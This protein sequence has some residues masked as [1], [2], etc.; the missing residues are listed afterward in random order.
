VLGTVD[1]K[2]ARTVLV[3]HEALERPVDLQMRL[4]VRRGCGCYARVRGSLPA[5]DST[6]V[7]GVAGVAAT[8]I[9]AWVA[10]WNTRKATE[11]TVEAGSGDNRTALI[12]AREDRLWERR[13]AAYEEMLAVVLHRKH[14]R[15]F[16]LVPTARIE[17]GTELQKFLD[18]VRLPGTFEAE[19]RLVAYAS[20]PVLAKYEKAD[21]W[22][23]E[24][25]VSAVQL[26]GIRDADD[27]SSTRGAAPRKLTQAEELVTTQLNGALSSA[28]MADQALIDVIRAEL[29][30][31][32]EA[33]RPHAEVPAPRRSLL[34]RRKALEGSEGRTQSAL[35]SRRGC[36]DRSG[37]D[38]CGRRRRRRLGRRRSIDRQLGR[39]LQ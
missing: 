31:R 22:H 35:P 10:S 6:I 34:R 28:N 33:V 11:R 2:N 38:R 12:S 32:P 24:S 37:M 39:Q 18:A 8:A 14:V 13:A 27:S 36:N 17:T 21:Q 20:E 23:R 5:M 25:V 9:T 15:G 4:A 7:V 19:S 16:D 30:S 1:L 26:N 3:G 29:R